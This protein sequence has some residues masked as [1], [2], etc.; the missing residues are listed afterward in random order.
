MITIDTNLA[1]PSS[2]VALTGYILRVTN[3]VIVL[4]EEE[5]HLTAH[6]PPFGSV[7][8]AVVYFEDAVAT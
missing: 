3:S 2:V 8:C 6:T 7:L 5:T 4:T 1:L